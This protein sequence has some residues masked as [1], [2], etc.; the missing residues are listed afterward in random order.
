MADKFIPFMRYTAPTR[1][2]N[3]LFQQDRAKVAIRR[4]VI[5]D[6]LKPRAISSSRPV[7]SLACLRLRLINRSILASRSK[8]HPLDDRI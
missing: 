6:N 4:D 2:N 3:R 8:A 1:A 5:N 7:R